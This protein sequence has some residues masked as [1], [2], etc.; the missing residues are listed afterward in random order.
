MNGEYAWVRWFTEF[1]YNLFNFSDGVMIWV[2]A[3]A[4]FMTVFYSAVCVL[5]IPFSVIHRVIADSRQNRFSMRH[6]LTAALY[7][8]PLLLPWAWNCKSNHAGLRI[9]YYVMINTMWFLVLV[10]GPFGLIAQMHDEFLSFGEYN[11]HRSQSDIPL[12]AVL[13]FAIIASVTL[14]YSIGLLIWKHC[15]NAKNNRTQEQDAVKIHFH[16]SVM[17]SLW[18]VSLLLVFL[19]NIWRD[20]LFMVLFTYQ[21]TFGW[22]VATFCLMVVKEIRFRRESGDTFAEGV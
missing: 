5:L 11:S 12:E 20:G 7:C 22:I 18:L 21:I 4:A 14:V 17:F 1:C 9:T 13:E 8:F 19:S 10:L 16:P 3:L 15:F 6:I 2:V